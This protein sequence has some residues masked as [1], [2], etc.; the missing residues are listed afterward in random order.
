VF[1][2]GVG[3]TLR[4][5]RMTWFR[6]WKVKDQG[7]RVNK[8]IFFTLMTITPMLLRIWLTTAIRR[9]FELY[10]CLLVCTHHSGSE[11]IALVAQCPFDAVSTS[12]LTFKT[13]H[14]RPP[15]YLS[16]ECQQV[17]AV[18]HGPRSSDTL[19]CVLLWT[20][21]RLGDRSLLWPFW[22]MLPMSERVEFNVPLDT[23]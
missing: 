20:D 11:G 22:N 17:L 21:N 15:P 16:D 3:M 5:P 7:H 6:G 1:N 14:G 10:E 9:W 4:Y 18:N 2:V 23:Q 8:C 12:S 13:L 19:T